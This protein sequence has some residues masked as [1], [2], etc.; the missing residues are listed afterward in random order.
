MFRKADGP[1]PDPSRIAVLAR[2]TISMWAD[3]RLGISSDFYEP[4]WLV[5]VGP[6][7]Y[8]PQGDMTLTFPGEA[9]EKVKGTDLGLL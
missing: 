1:L 5:R 7:A 2:P 3:S 6:A 4:V 8:S 9:P